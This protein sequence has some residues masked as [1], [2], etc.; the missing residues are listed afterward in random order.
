[1]S[2]RPIEVGIMLPESEWE[3][4]GQT[5]RWS[6][7]AAMGETIE[8]EGFDSLWFADHLQMTLPDGRQQGAW[9]AWSILAAFAATTKRIEIGPF[10]SPTSYRNPAMLVKTAETVD[11]ISGGRL[12]LGIGSGWAEKEYHVFG[13]P[14]DHRASRFEEALAIVTKLVRTGAVDFQGAYYEINGAENRPRGPRPEGMPI[15]IGTFNGE[16]MMKLAAR[17]ADHWN[18]WANAFG[19]RAELLAPIQQQMDRFCQESG[20]DPKSLKRSAAVYVDF[21][22]PYGRPGQPVP[23]LTGTPRQLADEYL[24]YAEAGVDLIQLYPDPCTIEGIKRC[25]EALALL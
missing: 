15:M 18:I 7:F 20:R 23:S 24:R 22:N 25:T 19:N 10:V 17:E 21:E 11:E 13:L 6:D 9:E 4:A 12:V 3:M 5:A 1:M 2:T 14:Y 8:A 16:R